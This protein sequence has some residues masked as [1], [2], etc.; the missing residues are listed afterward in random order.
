MPFLAI[1]QTLQHALQ[2]LHNSCFFNV[3]P[4]LKLCEILFETMESSHSGVVVVQF[5][6]SIFLTLCMVTGMIIST[7]L[8]GIFNSSLSQSIAHLYFLRRGFENISIG[9]EYFTTI[10]SSYMVNP[11]A[12]VIGKLWTIPMDSIGTVAMPLRSCFIDLSM[13]APMRN[14]IS[15]VII[16]IS[17]QESNTMAGILRRPILHFIDAMLVSGSFF[18]TKYISIGPSI[19][20]SSESW[21]E[22]GSASIRTGSHFL[23]C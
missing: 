14:T 12:K 11:G 19:D 17:E 7:P 2:A 10:K 13:T 23:A 1:L 8:W 22:M 9:L 15:S 16:A 18:R 5:T 3:P 20:S 4:S 6:S 21:A